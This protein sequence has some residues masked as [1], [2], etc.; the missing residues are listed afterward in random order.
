M[1][2]HRSKAA[3]GDPAGGSLPTGSCCDAG[4]SGD[5]GT[6]KSTAGF[7]M[8]LSGGVISWG[9]MSPTPKMEKPTEKDIA[10]SG[11]WTAPPP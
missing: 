10:P 5:I 1:H 11:E 9:S 2:T 4:L 7:G 6:R 8:V 3:I